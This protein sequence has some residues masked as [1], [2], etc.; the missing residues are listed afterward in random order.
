MTLNAHN[1]SIWIIGSLMPE[2]Q[3]REREREME[4]RASEEEGE[5]EWGQWA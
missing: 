5:R 4:R 1:K 3:K 2:E